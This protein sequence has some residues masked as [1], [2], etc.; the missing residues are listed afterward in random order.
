MIINKGMSRLR[1]E[2]YKILEF[3][4]KSGYSEQKQNI[5]YESKMNLIIKKLKILSEN[6]Q[7]QTYR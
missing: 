3:L 5:T 6:M 4:N 1:K 7:K 2:R